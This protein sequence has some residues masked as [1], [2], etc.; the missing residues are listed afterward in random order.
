[1]VPE[2]WSLKRELHTHCSGEMVPREAAIMSTTV[3]TFTLE[4]DLKDVK[5]SKLMQHSEDFANK[6]PEQH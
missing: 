1:M 3:E 4:A 2:Q 6:H 5:M